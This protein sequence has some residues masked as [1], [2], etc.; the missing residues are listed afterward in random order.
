M[1]SRNPNIRFFMVDA[2]G[3]AAA[4]CPALGGSYV[5]TNAPRSGRVGA[6]V[7]TNAPRPNQMG[8][9]VSTPAKLLGPIGSYVDSA[10]RS[11]RK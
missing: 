3:W 8:S 6:Y 11:S 4:G 5:T 10:A 9:Y 1:S 7:T 2:D